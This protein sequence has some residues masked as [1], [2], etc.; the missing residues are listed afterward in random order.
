DRRGREC[1]R[2]HRRVRPPAGYADAAKAA[3]AAPRLEN[4]SHR[5]S[6]LA[7][8]CGAHEPMARRWLAPNPQLSRFGSRLLRLE[9]SSSIM[10]G[11][12]PA[13]PAR[14]G[15]SMPLDYCHPTAPHKK[16][17]MPNWYVSS[18]MMDRALDAVAR[19][20]KKL[21]RKHDIPY[22]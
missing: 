1:R 4:A 12:C 14:G 19:K 3:T 22:V 17:R 10:A 6:L 13:D 18:L 9:C 7:L 5:P 8:S 2:P 20:V 11:C 16:L 15:V 21:D